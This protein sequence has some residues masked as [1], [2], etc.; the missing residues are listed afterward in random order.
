MGVAEVCGRGLVDCVPLAAHS[1]IVD[2]A[3]QAAAD[4]ALD[5]RGA[6]NRRCCDADEATKPLAGYREEK[7]AHAR[8]NFYGFDPSYHVARCNF[9]HKLPESHPPLTLAR[10]RR[11]MAKPPRTPHSQ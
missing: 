8:R 6:E 5:A 1:A 3:R 7:L 9:I 2:L 4:P 11:A 10:H